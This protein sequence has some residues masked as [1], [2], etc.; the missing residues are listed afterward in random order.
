MTTDRQQLG[1]NIPAET[2]EQMERIKEAT[3]ATFTN[4]VIRASEKLHADLFRDPASAA[5]AIGYIRLDR[6]GEIEAAEMTCAEC[7][8][9]LHPERGA[10]LAVLKA[11]EDI[12]LAGPLCSGCA[13]SA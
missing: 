12:T 6:L 1:L 8:Q 9:P 13:S 7:G 10:F 5:I 3:G 11:D 2:R 4:Q